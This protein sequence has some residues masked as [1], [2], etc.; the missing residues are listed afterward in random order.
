M[1]ATLRAQGIGGWA[2]LAAIAGGLLI[3][4]ASPA[5]AQDSGSP[6]DAEFARLSNKLKAGESVVI[7]TQD[8]KRIEGRFV[9][10]SL[11]RIALSRD[12]ERQE[13]PSQQVTRV[14]VRRNGMRL[15]P[16]IGALAGLGFGLALGSASSNE[17]GSA[18]VGVA[19]GVGIGAGAGLAIDAL[20]VRPRTVFERTSEGRSALS[21][22]VTPTRAQAQARIRF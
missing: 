6:N 15:G 22:V 16:V 12:D 10:V 19:L 3:V 13:V 14:Q 11:A 1:I 21:L 9:D 4:I 5:R 7:T 8:G 20:L 17:G 18:G 2:L